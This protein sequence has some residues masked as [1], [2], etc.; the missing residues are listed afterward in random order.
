[1]TD[2]WGPA[3]GLPDEAFGHDGLITKRHLRAS[4]LAHLRPASGQLLWDIGLGAGSVAIEWCRSADGC[5]A[6]GVEQRPERAERALANAARLAPAG[7]LEVTVGDALDAVATWRQGVAPDAVFIG[8]GAGEELLT[9]CWDSLRPG[10]RLVAHGVTVETEA[11][12]LSARAR[13][14]GAV[15]RLSVEHLEPLARWHG[16]AP[17]RP[18]VAWS[19]VR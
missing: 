10:G 11:C 9:A 5:R 16:W 8:G 1:M 19:V 14:G 13:W 7:S 4:A 15:A 18:V 6:L 12:L 2:N 17:Q 3:P